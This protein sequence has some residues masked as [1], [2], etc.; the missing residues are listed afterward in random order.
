MVPSRR[1]VLR[2]ARPP[3]RRARLLW[4]AALTAAGCFVA[5]LVVLILLRWLAPP[6]TALQVQRRL[7]GVA[8]RADV[9]SYF[10][11]L[12]QLPAYV[13]HAVVAAEDARF[14]THRGVDWTEVEKAVEQGWREGEARRGASTITQQLV[15]NLF[16]TTHGGYVR[17]AIEV[18]LSYLT[19]LILPKPRI[20][21]IY[22][23]VVEWG[24]GIYGIEAAAR[25]HYGTDAVQLSRERAARLAAILP[26]PRRRDPQR[27][28]QAM[29]RILRRM[30]EMGW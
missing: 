22:L 23:N 3:K 5:L 30:A 27:M 14:F 4:W 1:A 8:P 28:N 18:P 19:E 17:K 6:V 15:K 10:V 25:F 11:A 29:Q 13:P 2:Q 16:L 12:D 21:E 9:P 26:A 7:E 20:L 24:A